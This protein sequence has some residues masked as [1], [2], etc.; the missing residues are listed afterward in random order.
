MGSKAF[1]GVAGRFGRF[2]R[3]FSGLHRLL[4]RFHGSLRGISDAF[5]GVLKRFNAFLGISEGSDE[6]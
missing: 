6:F 3:N 4:G 5:Q 2:Q 1:Q